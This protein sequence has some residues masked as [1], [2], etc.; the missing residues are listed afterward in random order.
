MFS[1]HIHTEQAGHSVGEGPGI[2]GKWNHLEWDA[3][4][5]IIWREP[6]SLD[7]LILWLNAPR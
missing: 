5:N 6:R 2:L 4:Q 3:A 1:R 7:V